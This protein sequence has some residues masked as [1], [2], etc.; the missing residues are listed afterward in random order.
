[1]LE[2]FDRLPLVA[3]AGQ[4]LDEAPQENVARNQQE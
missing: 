3:I 2:D 4:D 1:M